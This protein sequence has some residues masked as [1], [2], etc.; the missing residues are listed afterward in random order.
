MTKMNY[1][2]F[3]DRY[4]DIHEN[5]LSSSIFDDFTK[6]RYYCVVISGNIFI[7]GDYR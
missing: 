2:L 5:T 4:P 6:E 1:T 7:G 3:L